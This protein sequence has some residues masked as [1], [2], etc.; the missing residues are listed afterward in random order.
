MR[1]NGKDR[2]LRGM[3]D[4][5]VVGVV[6]NFSEG[7]DAEVIDA[8]VAALHVPGARVV[9]AEADADH[10]RLDTTVLGSPDAVRRQ[11]D[12]RRRGGGPSGSTCSRTTAVIPG[13]A[14]RT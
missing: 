5:P 1:G 2:I 12:G 7:R 8:I 11:R 4:E 3:A 10:H 14:R 9:Y 13:W 6:P